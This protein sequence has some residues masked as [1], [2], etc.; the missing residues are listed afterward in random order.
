MASGVSRFLSSC[1]LAL[2]DGGHLFLTT[3][4]PCSITA[5]HHA[6]H[7]QPPMIYI[8]HT[9][10]YPPYQIDEMLRG[11]GFAIV[12]RETI[13]VWRNAIS[14]QAHENITRFIQAAGYPQELR[15]EDTF[16]LSHKDWSE[17]K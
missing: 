3:P 12:R 6:L 14:D 8:P 13:D 1:A 11:A 15:G 10:E 9:R 4:N 17:S 5:I 7:L 16:I 2:R